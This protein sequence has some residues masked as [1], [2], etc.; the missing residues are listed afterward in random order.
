MK[1]I[2]SK[3]RTKRTRSRERQVGKAA[4]KTHAW[5]EHPALGLAIA[6]ATW[7]L[8]IAI[9]HSGHI[10]SRGV[11]LSAFL[12][13]SGH[14]IILLA[15][16]L[17]IG[18]LL[19][20]TH[21]TLLAKNSQILLL[22]LIVI[23]S[24]VPAKMLVYTSSQ[25]ALFSPHILP[26]V[27]TFALAPIVA[28]ILINGV[29]GVAAGL[30]C[31]LVI[32]ILI[33]GGLPGFLAGLVVTLVA[34]HS[35]EHVRTRSKVVRV[36][37]MAGITEIA[38]VFAITAMNWETA[39]AIIVLRQAAACVVSGFLSAILALI[40]IPIFEKSFRITTDITWLELAD[41]SHP[42][43]QRLAMEAPG[44]YHHSLVVSSLA[45]AAAEEIGAN[46]LIARVTSYFHDVGKLN[47]PEFFAE[48]MRFQHNPHDDLPPSMSMLIITSHVKEGVSLALHH[49]LPDRII[50][51]IREH[52]GTS[53]VSYFHRKAVSQ[54]ENGKKGAASSVKNTPVEEWN[55]RYDGP[56]PTSRES[57]IVNLA[58]PV[59]AASRSLEKPTA[60]SIEG[61]IDDIIEERVND[62]QL[63]NSGLTLAE[64]TQIK[65][66]FMFTLTSIF[67]GRTP[68]PKNGNT[69]AQSTESV[70]A[71]D[72]A[73]SEAPDVADEAL[74]SDA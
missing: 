5:R 21:P 47:K 54:A 68:Y 17:S 31:S 9:L 36:G 71:P 42:L 60:A 14:A 38:F 58:D 33:G 40:I 70:Q 34:S 23:A 27:M 50:D 4:Q 37:I 64:L 35:A 29:T 67:H 61:L 72:K 24:I 73:P 19:K 57:G 62:G 2:V 63:D 51:V 12:H 7:L 55:F 18:L 53:V 22:A 74:D 43:L 28:T 8:T 69:P 44:T 16:L 66:A 39:E 52:H 49:R 6:L 46:S 3:E 32:T 26:F 25:T 30:W 10:V 59:E 41:L 56:K 65:N 13:L 11:S 48:N 15:G 1:N 45:Q 20:L